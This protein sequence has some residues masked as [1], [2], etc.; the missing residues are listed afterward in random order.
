MIYDLQVLGHTPSNPTFYIDLAKKTEH[1]RCDG[2]SSNSV[3]A[4]FLESL[5]TAYRYHI[6]TQIAT[7]HFFYI[8]RINLASFFS[9]IIFFAFKPSL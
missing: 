4:L 6:R 2:T 8:S 9:L 5:I 7:M 3:T 1:N